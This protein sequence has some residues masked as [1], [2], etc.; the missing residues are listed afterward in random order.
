MSSSA[1]DAFPTIKSGI[2]I[3]NNHLDQY[4]DDFE[5]PLQSP[6]TERF[7]GGSPHRHQDLNT[8][9]TADL[10]EKRPEAYNLVENNNTSITLEARTSTQAASRYYRDGL[11]KRPVNISNIKFTKD[12]K[13]IG[14]YNKDYEVV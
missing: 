2:L 9:S 12:S 8:A 6:F 11:A 1:A 4:G 5:I 10:S 3:T 7:I 13:F 14:N